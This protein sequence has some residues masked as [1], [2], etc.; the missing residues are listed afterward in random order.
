MTENTCRVQFSGT[1]VGT[2]MYTDK[3]PHA[4]FEY[5][6]AWIES[7]FSVSPLHMPLTK[8]VYKFPTLS[9]DTYKGLPA[10]F[11]DSLPDDFGNTLINSWLI[12]TGQ[13]TS[14]I[15]AIDRLLYTG[16]RGM[17]GLEYQN[18]INAFNCPDREIQIVE[19]LK[20]AQK[21]LD[22]R[23]EGGITYS[24]VDSMKQLM[25]IGTSAGGARP[26]AVIAINDD[27]TRIISGHTDSPTGFEHYL[28]KFDGITEH[29]ADQQTFGDPK[30]YGLMEYAYYKMATAC[31]LSM[32]PCE[33]LHENGRSHF[34]TKRFDRVNNRKYHTLSLCGM[35]HADF[36]KP[37]DF[38]YEELLAV[39]RQLNLT[40]K[41]QIEIY[42][43][44][45]FNVI[46]RNQDDHAKN[47]AFYVDDNLEW[48]L[49]PAY[50]IAFSYR[51]DSIWVASHQ[52]SIN[53]KR[54]GFEREDLLTV[55]SWISGLTPHKANLLIDQV[56]DVVAGW[57]EVAES[58]GVFPEL[59]DF[60]HENLRLTI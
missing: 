31:G 43:R 40:P 4:S 27:R 50:D 57:P 32:M 39:A 47:T 20:V 23:E 19:M 16:T 21:V 10:V 35:A 51:K 8:Q 56:R 55:A 30:G 22:Q 6:P 45:V 33:L 17:G 48:R 37:G 14:Q 46:A 42:R 5:D 18:S 58:V 24:D 13:D 3:G 53:G 1:D 26:K 7:G 41:E 12:Q 36:R 38:S 9:L 44:M 29:R 25:L 52:M 49:A 2:L 60:I 54:D 59:S 34:M 28:L 15:S 11:S